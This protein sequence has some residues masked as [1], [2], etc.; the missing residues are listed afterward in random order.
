MKTTSTIFIQYT[1]IE[2]LSNKETFNTVINIS[3]TLR[4]LNLDHTKITN[5]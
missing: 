3:N 4:F 2:T 1:P 5:S